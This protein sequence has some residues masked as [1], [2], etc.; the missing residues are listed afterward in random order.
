MASSTLLSTIHTDG[1]IVED[2]KFET[3][4]RPDEYAIQ[5]IDHGR[6]CE[7]FKTGAYG[8]TLG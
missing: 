4:Y 2:E 3:V 7:K 6:T 1:N 8:C 5:I